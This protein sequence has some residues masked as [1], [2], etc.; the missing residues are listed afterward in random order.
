MTTHPDWKGD[1]TC[2]MSCRDMDKSIRWYQDV[3]GFEVLYRLDDMGWCELQT[4]VPGVT[5]GLSQVE[6]PAR[7]GG[8]TLTFGVKDIAGARASLE[9]KDVRFDGPT[10]EIEGMV[11]LATFYDL[12]GNALMFAQSLAGAA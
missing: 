12:D 10:R 6:G 4:A 11:K 7:G 9:A 8:A 3:L 1:L 2:A 5:I